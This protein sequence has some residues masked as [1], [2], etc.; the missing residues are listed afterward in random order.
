MVFQILRVNKIRF[1][2]KTDLFLLRSYLSNNYKMSAPP[3][4]TLAGIPCTPPEEGEMTPLPAGIM[5]DPITGMRALLKSPTGPPLTTRSL[6]VQPT[7]L[8]TGGPT[9]TKRTLGEGSRSQ[10]V[11]LPKRTALGTEKKD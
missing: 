7:P 3:P 10:P 5:R 1:K 8:P 6:A 2:G 11:P 4:L 9:G